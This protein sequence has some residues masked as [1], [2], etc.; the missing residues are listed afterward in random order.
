MT[1]LVSRIITSVRDAHVAFDERTVPSGPLYRRLADVCGE[2]QAR[3]AALDSTVQG[4]EQTLVFD[5]PLGDFDAGLALGAGRIV[6]DVSA[7]DPDTVPEAQRRRYPIEVISR[8]QRF[9]GNGPSMAAWEEGGILYLRGPASAWQRLGAIEV[10]TILSFGDTEADALQLPS[11]V[12][13]LPDAAASLV[14]AELALFAATRVKGMSTT[15]FE[16]EVARRSETFYDTITSRIAGR[17]VFTA[18]VMGYY[19]D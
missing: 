15:A 11:A 8:D 12:L 3:I 19:L 4:I 7:L 17:R 5:L 1:R 18:D 16:R 14:I 9:A 10:Q 6:T 13:P 2:V